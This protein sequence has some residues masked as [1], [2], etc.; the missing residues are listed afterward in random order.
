MRISP[1]V[2]LLPVVLLLLPFIIYFPRT[3]HTLP[4][5]PRVDVLAL[6]DQLVQVSEGDIGYTSV[7]AGSYFAALDR[8]GEASVM[9]LSNE[10]LAPSEVLRRIVRQ[11]AAAVP[12]LIAHLDDRR[13]TRLEVGRDWQPL[14]VFFSN[15][16]DYN[17]RTTRP[18][19]RDD[20]R[21]LMTLLR[22][23]AAEDEP[24]THTITVGDLCY[25]ALGQIVNRDFC[26]VRYQPTAL[27]IIT[28]P[29]HSAAL[30]AAVR[31]E[32]GSLTPER[33]REALLRDFRRPDHLGRITGACRRL[34]YYYPDTFEDLI[35][36]WLNAPPA[37]LSDD[38]AAEIIERGLMDDWS[39]RIDRAVRDRLVHTDNDRLALACMKRLVGR[40]YDAD[41]EQYCRRR[42]PVAKEWR[43][44][45]QEMLNKIGWTRLHVAVQ[46]Q[47]VEEVRRL[48]RRGADVNAQTREG[49]TPLHMAAASGALGIV[50]ALLRARP[51]L[52]VPNRRGLTPVQLAATADHDPI[53]R[54]LVEHGC[55]VPNL[56]VAAS[57]GSCDQARV[58]IADKPYTIDMVNKLG[59]SPLYLAARRGDPAMVAL[60]LEQGATLTCADEQGGVPLHQA[61]YHGHLD[62]VRI[63]LSHGALI[64]AALD[65]SK[66]TPLHIAVHEKYAAMVRLLLTYKPRLDMKAGKGQT[67][68]HLAAGS[69]DTELARML[70][71][72]GAPI[73]A[74]DD[75]KGTPL[76]DAVAKGAAAMAKLLL[77]AGADV[78]AWKG[79][80]QALHIAAERGD[81]QL[82]EILLAHKA[83]LEGDPDLTPLHRAATTGQLEAARL[84]L[85]HGANVNARKGGGMTP[86]LEAVRGGHPQLVRLL[87]EHHADVRADSADWGPLLYAV[88]EGKVDIARILV[89]H[90]ADINPKPD[91][92]YETLLHFAVHRQ[93]ADMVRLLLDRGAVVDEDDVN[94]RTP[95]H[96]AAELNQ[97]PI[98][99]LLL[100]HKANVRAMD[101]DGLEPIHMAA[102]LEDGEAMTALL[103]DHKADINARTKYEGRT[104]L[105]IAVAEPNP[106]VVRVLLERGAD[107]N[108]KD[109]SE[110]TALE[111]ARESDDPD[112]VELF[113][114]CGALK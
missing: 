71:A 43:E 110:W 65:D 33:H 4:S 80:A 94:W 68:L 100:E 35:V 14:G 69:G 31:E 114:H 63:L 9:L 54:R 107:W 16:P 52:D 72:A 111:L 46:R 18:P 10:R 57:A 37:W 83:E 56:L 67:P 86:L 49:D 44:S 84:L 95:L 103:L 97:V 79:A 90:R 30:C 92:R 74:R 1:A 101:R 76:H 23:G 20:D 29:T 45:F 75:E 70:L 40:G 48:I 34:A 47:S 81:L 102:A 51:H 88:L 24:S 2:R 113:R 19:G 3:E 8:E 50:E 64:N 41:I 105:H 98:A 91:Q 15:T 85:A 13:P 5:Q 6:I 12:H 32:W 58:L 26:A 22:R 96:D 36:P 59:R 106:S 7:A 27:I 60:L 112:I 62:V 28:S 99:R 108:I 77:A 93:N 78:N 87:C 109:D 55:R 53:V 17:A 82:M 25:V 42:M 89:D 73:N 61:V 104:A 21:D 38:L 39:E 11:G 66:Y